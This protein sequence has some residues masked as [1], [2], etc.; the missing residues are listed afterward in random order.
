MFLNFGVA[1]GNPVVRIFLG[2]SGHNPAAVLLALK[3][4]AF[5]F[6]FFAW[7]SGRRRLLGHINLLFAA[8]VA[9]N[10]VALIAFS[11]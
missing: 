7:R 9:W 5:A 10:I 8:C 4:V 11:C 1:E 6:A 2:G 3:A